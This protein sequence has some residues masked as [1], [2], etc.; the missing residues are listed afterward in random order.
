MQK[1][2]SYNCPH[3]DAKYSSLSGWNAHIEKKHPETIPEGYTTSQYF[4]YVLTGKSS[5]VCPIC[6][7]NTPWNDKS[8]KYCRMCGSDECR[9]ETARIAD[10]RNMRVFGKAKVIDDPDFQIKMLKNRKISGTYTFED[11][12][13]VDYVGSYEK[14][15]L[16]MMDQFMEW[17]SADILGPSP[18][19]YTYIYEG[20]E[21]FYIPDYFITTL[22]IEVEIKSQTNMHHKIQAVDKVKEAAKDKVMAKDKSITYLKLN[23]KNYNLFFEY[24]LARKEMEV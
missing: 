14:D 23:D 24:L 5:G 12:G 11:E 13:N 19:I 15:F 10:E 7:G 4:Y 16:Q 8:L 20:K 18:N 3:C 1:V 22:G 21:H 9:K 17:N 6:K 2:K